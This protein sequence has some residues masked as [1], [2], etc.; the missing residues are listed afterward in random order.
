MW[1]ARDKDNS[2]YLYDTKPKKH[3]NNAWDSDGDGI[4]HIDDNLFPEV[5]WED[6][7]PLEVDII[8]KNNQREKYEESKSGC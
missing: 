5:K 1:V 2:L 3:R 7:E 6:D 8:P 4:V